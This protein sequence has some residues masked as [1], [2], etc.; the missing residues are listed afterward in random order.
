[1]KDKVWTFEELCREDN[2]LLANAHR[3]GS[4]E[5][6]HEFRKKKFKEL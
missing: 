2:I 6:L 1:M 4:I 5:P 3:G